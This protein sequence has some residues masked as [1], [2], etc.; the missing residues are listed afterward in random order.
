MRLRDFCA[1]PARTT[2]HFFSAEIIKCDGI[3]ALD[4]GFAATDGAQFGRG[5]SFFRET[6]QC[7]VA[8]K[9]YHGQLRRLFFLL[10]R[11]ARH[12][13][14][15]RDWNFNNVSLLIHV[16]QPSALNQNVKAELLISIA[17][18]MIL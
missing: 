16:F 7:D 18:W 1:G 5:W 15:H 13:S 9:R 8:L 12:S 10:P 14:P 4:R 2:R 17:L 3:A 6:R 11:S